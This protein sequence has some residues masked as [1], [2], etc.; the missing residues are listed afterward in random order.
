MKN[1]ILKKIIPHVIAIVLFIIVG[2]VYFSP[3]LQGYDLRQSDY[4]NYIGMSK[5]IK[6]YRD[7]AN[8]DPLWTNSMFSGMPAYQIDTKH[9]NYIAKLRNFIL[10]DTLNTPLVYMFL[11]FIGF[12]LL[13]ICLNVSPWLSIIGSIAFGL[14]TINI[15]YLGGG[16]ITKVHSIALLP[17]ILGSILYSYRKNAI[18]GG[19][20]FALFICLNLSANHIQETYYM[21]FFIIA[22]VIVELFRHFKEKILAKFIKASIIIMIGGFLGVLPNLSNLLVTYEYGEYTTRGKTELTIQSGAENEVESKG[23]DADYIKQYSLGFGEAW[24]LIIPNVKGGPSGYIGNNDKA[25]ENVSPAWKENIAQ[26]NQYWGEQL[27]TGGAFYFGITIFLLFFLGMFFVKDKIKWAVLATSILAVMLSWKF[28]ALTDFFIQH[29]PLFSKFRDTK[30]ILVLVQIA[31]P[32]M[33]ILF[34]KEIIERQIDQKKLLIAAGSLFLVLFLFWATPKTF[35]D[36]LS[37]QETVQFDQQMNSLKGDGAS[38]AQFETYQDELENAR[39]GIF[40]A[41]VLRSIIFLLLIATIVIIYNRKKF[42]SSY[43]I[44]GLGLLILIDLWA[45]DKRYLNNEKQGAK[46]N[47]WVKEYDKYN[48]YYAQSYDNQILAMEI[49]ANPK[50]K[51]IIDTETN[52]YIKDNDIKGKNLAHEKEKLA[53]RE[54]NLNT[55]YR[56]FELQNP[57]NSSRTSY[58]HKS[59]G[60]YHGAKLKR[61][62]ELIEFHISKNN[63]EV[64]NMLNTK[65]F[66]VP[67][68]D[69]GI[70]VQ[71]NP[72][73][74]GNAWFV[75]NYQLVENA[76]SEI[77][78]L[79]KINTAQTA[80]ID[81]R[82]SAEISDLKIGKDSTAM[83][84]MDSYAPNK[85]VY[86]SDTKS[87][88][89]AVFSEI[90][91][92][93]GWNAYMDNQPVS[94]FRAN[95]VLRAMKIPAGKHKIEF[96][97]EPQT[98]KTGNTISMAG[99]FLLIFLLLG[100]SFVEIKKSLKKKISS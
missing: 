78:A 2:L 72:Y 49:A 27:F 60:G 9:S 74:L 99:S 21:I 97:F 75:D 55:N 19:L 92:D 6:D 54:L 17:P 32:L 65:Y 22:V 87:E 70:V 51:E 90:Y 15:L 83:I 81:K 66:I 20:L 62:Q 94:Y 98:Y 13:L 18:V 8:E 53:F 3:Q 47:N 34:L 100:I 71:Q 86:T 33:G 85:I 41:D 11:C 69:Q 28:G 35:F 44:V 4:D 39:I 16:H 31:F 80:V 63:M 40:K 58:F 56:V 5:E 38:I 64:L 42:N 59:I 7:K 88:Q 24:S 37:S 89:L 61:Y 95:Y 48:P 82:F 57:F 43:L 79:D 50:L 52:K 76:D 26:S 68:K 77:V 96:R 73:T 45:V 30:M 46:Y 1:P 84:Y 14:S 67:T 29:V 23:L 10:F 93:K 25:M 91:Y 36:F 12:Y